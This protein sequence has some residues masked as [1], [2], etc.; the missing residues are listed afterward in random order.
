LPGQVTHGWGIP[1][2]AR[3]HGNDHDWM[4]K[5]KGYTGYTWKIWKAEK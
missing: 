1:I 4:M 2:V 5:K 3:S